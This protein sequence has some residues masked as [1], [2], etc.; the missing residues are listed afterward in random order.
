M[1]VTIYVDGFKIFLTILGGS[2]AYLFELQLLLFGSK[3]SFLD[4][5]FWLMAFC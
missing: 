1:L 2:M 5:I 4:F 3:A